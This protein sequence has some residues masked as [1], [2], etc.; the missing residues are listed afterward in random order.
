[1][2]PAPMIIC[3]AEFFKGSHFSIPVRQL[4]LRHLH[5]SQP[6]DHGLALSA[7]SENLK[8]QTSA[9]EEVLRDSAGFPMNY[10]KTRTGYFLSFGDMGAFPHTPSGYGT[11]AGSK[12]TLFFLRL[13]IEFLEHIYDFIIFN[14]SLLRNCYCT[15]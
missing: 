12:S 15:W 9:D 7:G 10:D 2:R 8:V 4:I 13:T 5:D 11:N 14:F 1:M 3:P 6:C